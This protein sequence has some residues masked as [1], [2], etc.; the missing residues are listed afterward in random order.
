MMKVEAETLVIEKNNAANGIVELIN[1]NRITKLVMGTSSISTKRKV[2]NSKV[3]GFV[4][5]KAE[6]YCQIF[7]IRRESLACTR[8]TNMD[9]VKTDSPRS[10]SASTLSHEPE[11]P[12]RS[13]SLPPGHPGYMSSPDQ[14]FLPQRSYSVSYPLSV[15]TAHDNSVDRTPNN[16]SPNAS[17]PS[18]RG[19][20][21]SSLKDLDSTEGSPAPASVVSC[22]EQQ[23][24]MVNTCMHSEV[25]EQLQQV[26]AELERSRKEAS[27]GRQKAERELF[28]ASMK[29]KAREN[30][31]RKEKRE[32]EERLTREKAILEKENL[33]ICNELQKA[34]EQS[35]ELEKSLLQ[36]ISLLEELRRLQGDLQRE[37]E[38]ALRAAEEMRRSIDTGGSGSPGGVSL[39]EFS[40]DEIKEAQS[41]ARANVACL[42][43]PTLE[44][45]SSTTACLSHPTLELMWPKM[46]DYG[47]VLLDNLFSLPLRL[48]SKGNKQLNE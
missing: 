44:M 41:H 27:D 1:Q 30:S 31:L 37:K 8:E 43:H 12:A 15:S 48:S 28:E 10:S 3:A 47:S 13:V 16:C 9:S 25:F 19:S 33:K 20:S 46:R 38:E 40:Y 17:L 35:A 26:R 32:V 14:L 22:E 2:P 6:A 5:Q 24:S 42:S 34:N 4:H 29:F 39:T 21:S 18:N 7:F 45:R 11:W 36:T 23:I